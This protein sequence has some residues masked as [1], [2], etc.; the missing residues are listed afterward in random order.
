MTSVFMHPFLGGTPEETLLIPQHLRA[1]AQEKRVCG[2][3]RAK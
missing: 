2:P 3:G 1:E